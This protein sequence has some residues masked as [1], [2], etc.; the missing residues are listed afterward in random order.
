MTIESKIKTQ[1]AIIGWSYGGYLSAMAVCRKRFSVW[2]DTH[3]SLEHRKMATDTESLTEGTV[4]FTCAIAGAP[5]TTWTGYDTHYTERYMGTPQDNAVGY[6]S[7][8]VS[9]H[10]GTFDRNAQ[11]VHVLHVL[12][13]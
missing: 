6:R 2:S 13:A 4:H 8:S 1:A 3:V 10:V 7:S 12:I 9:Q 11:C 5:V